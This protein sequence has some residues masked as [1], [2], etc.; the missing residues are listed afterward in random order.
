VAES[1]KDKERGYLKKVTNI[2]MKFRQI[3]L[4]QKVCRSP[5][6]HQDELGVHGLFL[7]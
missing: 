7:I 5:N 6:F 3:G 4:R 1:R 2:S